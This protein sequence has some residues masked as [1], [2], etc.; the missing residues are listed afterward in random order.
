M[1][2]S[3][4]RARSSASAPQGYQST[5]FSECCRRYGLVSSASR[6]GMTRG[7]GPRMKSA[8]E[9][10]E[11]VM[12]PRSSR[13]GEKVLPEG[14]FGPKERDAVRENRRHGHPPTADDPIPHPCRLGLPGT[15]VVSSPTVPPTSAPVVS[16][17]A[18]RDRVRGWR[19]PAPG[20]RV[21]ALPRLVRPD[22]ERDVR[23]AT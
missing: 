20:G 2:R 8:A 21:R 19:C 23:S 12:F 10:V 11:S 14:V 1:G 15:G 4:D 16:A 7:S 5:G 18:A 13:Q 6:L 17:L 3:S 22:A 9:P